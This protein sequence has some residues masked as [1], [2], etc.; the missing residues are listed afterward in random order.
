M[1]RLASLFAAL[2]LSTNAVA[3]PARDAA[4]PEGW[5]GARLLALIDGDMSATAYADGKLYPIGDAKDLVAVIGKDK[6]VRYSP[7]AVSNTV[8]GWPGS[9]VVSNDGRRAFVV[10]SRK[11][12]A[13]SVD[14]VKDG[15]FEAF[16]LHNA[17]TIVLTETGETLGAAR[18]C[19]KPLSIDLSP[20]NKWALI[21]CGD[22]KGELAVA[23]ITDDGIGAVRIFD[24]AVPT[25]TDAAN[26]EGATYAVVHPSGAAAGVVL[27]NRAVT[28]VR[29]DL[30]T[31]GIPVAAKAETPTQTKSWLSVARWTASGAHLLVSDVAWGPRPLDAVFNKS[32]AILSFALAPDGSARGVTSKAR[33][34][35]SPEAFELNR[36]GDLLVAVNMERTYLPGGAT[37]VFRGRSAS[38]LSLVSVDPATGALKTL[39]KPVRFRGVL[40]EDAVFDADGDRIAAIVYQD[41]NKPRSDG[42][43]TFFRIDGDGDNR[44][45]TET[46]A[47]IPLP[48]GGHDLAVID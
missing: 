3:E 5:D 10:S 37:S 47:R 17:L 22:A 33:V 4:L 31:D 6:G 39:G 19:E 1:V 20:D 9:M 23:P 36:T 8:M 46:D 26:D 15:V 27:N 28:L 38:S 18:V 21:A 13:R 30:D 2:F 25:Y 41:H 7:A 40:P 29:F 48:R 35:K 11:G 12:M 14:K 32:G 42:W 44:R 16:P 45:L 43:I 34:S 24:L